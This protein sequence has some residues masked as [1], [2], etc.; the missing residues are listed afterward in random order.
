MH[1]EDNI[2]YISSG[3]SWDLRSWEAKK[4]F[5]RKYWDLFGWRVLV[6]GIWNY[7]AKRQKNVVIEGQ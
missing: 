2:L 7:K 6:E 5:L 4:W 1:R 3:M